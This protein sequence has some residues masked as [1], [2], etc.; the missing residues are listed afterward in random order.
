MSNL[1]LPMLL[2]FSNGFVGFCMLIDDYNK[3]SKR[4]ERYGV[5]E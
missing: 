2:G 3:Y 5:D 4:Y 1:W